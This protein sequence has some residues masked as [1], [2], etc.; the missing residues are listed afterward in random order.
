MEPGDLAT[1]GARPAFGREAG[2]QGAAPRRPAPA[3]PPAGASNDSDPLAG[4]RNGARPATRLPDSGS[5]RWNPVSDDA[6][7]VARGGGRQPVHSSEGFLRGH[8]SRRNL[9][10]AYLLWF[11]LGQLSM[12]RFYCGQT[13][14][15]WQQIGLLFGSVLVTLVF[16]P[17]GVMGIVVWLLWL[18]A[19]LFLIP[20][21]LGRFNTQ[22][23]S[24]Y[25]DF[26]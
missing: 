25:L 24:G 12:H 18:L 11:L 2:G 10:V 23:A 7:R 17:L 14:S 6:L 20:G 21:M 4:L 1:S 26:L 15:A 8:P 5:E 22:Q 13:G 19:D 9:I 16:P 3:E